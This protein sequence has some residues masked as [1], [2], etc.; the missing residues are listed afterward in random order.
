ME[1]RINGICMKNKIVNRHK[2]FTYE[3]AEISIVDSNA[4]CELCFMLNYGTRTTR[5]VKH[6]G[7]I[8][9]PTFTSEYVQRNCRQSVS[10]QHYSLRLT[11][12][13]FISGVIFRAP[14][15][16]IDRR[17]SWGCHNRLYT[18]VWG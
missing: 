6:D 1:V 11:K 13:V 15:S 14:L 3:K 12:T 16:E 7:K 5:T 17:V 8:L 9:L 10:N 18:I 2:N 4:L